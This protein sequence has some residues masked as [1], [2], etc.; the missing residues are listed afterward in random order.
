MGSRNINIYS[1][2]V[3]TPPGVVIAP[4]F[5][6]KKAPRTGAP[7]RDCPSSSILYCANLGKKFNIKI[8][9]GKSGPGSKGG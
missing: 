8:R 6:G 5:E 1:F 7:E 9:G 4:F 2:I 3:E